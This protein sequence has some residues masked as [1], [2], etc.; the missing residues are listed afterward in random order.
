MTARKT[1]PE[2]GPK[3]TFLVVE[4]NL[5]YQSKRHGELVLNLDFPFKIL[6]DAMDTSEEEPDQFMKMLEALGDTATIRKVK[7]MG[8]LEAMR[9]IR[10]FFAEF[11]KQAG[12]G[13]GESDSSSDS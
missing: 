1:T 9:L 10:R 11:E 8:S 3:P 4:D 7:D 5:H 12:A 6:L 2:P 13:L